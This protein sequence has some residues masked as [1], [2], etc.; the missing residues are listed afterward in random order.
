MGDKVMVATPGF[1]NPFMDASELAVTGRDRARIALAN[2]YANHGE[3]VRRIRKGGKVAEIQ[4]AGGR[5]QPEKQVAAEMKRRY[6]V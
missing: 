6:R 5:S 4:F 2:G 1:W 3:E